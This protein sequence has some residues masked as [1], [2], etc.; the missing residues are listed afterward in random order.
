MENT[1]HKLLEGMWPQAEE[2]GMGSV[3]G[4]GGPQGE[5]RQVA[6]LF[7]AWRGQSHLDSS[8]KSSRP[9]VLAQDWY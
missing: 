9:K 7:M 6:H 1:N 4:C 2:K 5:S 3:P 8:L